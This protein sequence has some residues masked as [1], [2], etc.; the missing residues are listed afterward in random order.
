[1]YVYIILC[2]DNSLYTGVAKDIVKRLSEHYYQ[3][4]NCAK[5]TKSHKM[6]CLF[7]LFKTDN[8]SDAMKLEYSIKKLTHKEKL[9]LSFENLTS[10][11]SIFKFLSKNSYEFEIIP[12][13]KQLEIFNQVVSQK[14]N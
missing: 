14:S 12:K 8:K 3:K 7:S 11:L 4:K 6:V 2:D 1:M 9:L 10:D 5:Y 13:E